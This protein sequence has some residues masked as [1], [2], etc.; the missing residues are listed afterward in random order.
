MGLYFQRDIK[1]FDDGE[2]DLSTGDLA[3]TGVQQSQRQ[4][5]ITILTTTRGDMVQ[6]HLVGWGGDDYIGR[7][8]A[9][10]THKIM[11]KDIGLAFRLAHDLIPEDLDWKVTFADQNQAA[12]I[13]AHRGTFVEP[14]GSTPST[15]IV[16]GWQ[17]PFE[18]GKI[19]L[20][21]EA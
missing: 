9:G 20:V 2:L 8:N 11:D 14:D 1:Q 16:L 6:D 4:L 18:T 5:I 12:I 3:V 15:P 21:E 7:P 13:V 17:Y 19:E 10:T